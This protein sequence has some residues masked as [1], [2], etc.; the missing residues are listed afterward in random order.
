MSQ[1]RR[2]E[3]GPGCGARGR[4]RGQVGPAHQAPLVWRAPERP[5]GTIGPGFGARGR[6][7]D[8]GGK[9][10]LKSVENGQ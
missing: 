1:S 4:R 3:S 5:E 10:L 7:T 6:E 8:M 2:A 9:C